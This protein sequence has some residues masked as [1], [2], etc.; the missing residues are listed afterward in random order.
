MY[1]RNRLCPLLSSLA[2]L[3][4]TVP[5]AA[6]DEGGA[7][8]DRSAAETDET[9]DSESSAKPSEEGGEPSGTKETDATG[10]NDG[11]KETSSKP[12]KDRESEHGSYE[13]KPSFGAGLEYGLFFTQL[14]RWNTHLL[15][16]S[17][18]P[19]FDIDNISSFQFV[20]EASILEGSRFSLFAGLDSPFSNNPELMAVYGGVEPAF[21][22]RRGD[23]E[24]ALGVGVGLGS[25][26][27][28]TRA[29]SEFDA[30]LVTVR[31]TFELRRYVD[32][33]A[34]GYLRFG[35]NQWLPFNPESD[36]LEIEV[37]EGAP[38][39]ATE[40]VVR[41]RRVRGARCAIRP[42]SKTRQTGPGYRRRRSPRRHRR[43]QRRG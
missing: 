27:L 31:P 22:F 34:A 38:G 6:Q 24:M 12:N 20:A 39:Q 10:G 3:L 32:E 35:F 5:A 40:S 7:G 17:D 11:S 28:S 41:R 4:I 26:S 42:L 13:W 1:W 16:P 15:E 2:F 18:A 19:A 21:A 33:F 14:E 23:W 9:D 29:G 25:V 36:D 43:L 30:G 8:G 37:R